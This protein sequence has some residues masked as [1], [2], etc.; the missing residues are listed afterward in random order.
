[1]EH[2]QE[3]SWDDDEFSG[4]PVP[5]VADGLDAFDDYAPQQSTEAE[6]DFTDADPPAPAA[7]ALTVFTVANPLSSVT[8][9]STLGG[10]IHKVELTPKAMAMTETELADEILVIA[11]LARQKGGAAQHALMLAELDLPADDATVVSGFFQESMDLP[12]PEQAATAEAE[13]FAT[14]YTTR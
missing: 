8:V 1:M 10:P 7:P 5:P 12:T 2:T 13:V 14:R 4:Q 3:S 6:P 11:E 9:S